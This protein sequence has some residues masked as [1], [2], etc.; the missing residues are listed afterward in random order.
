V[1]RPPSAADFSRESGGRGGRR[2]TSRHLTK[3]PRDAGHG[4]EPRR[5]LFFGESQ[6]AGPV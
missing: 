6:T 1:E 2:S 3:R 5:N 4:G